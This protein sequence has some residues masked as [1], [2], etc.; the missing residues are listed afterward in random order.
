MREFEWSDKQGSRDRKA[1][2]LLVK[3][4]KI[5]AFEGANV[6][7]VAAIKGSDYEKSGKWS[8]TT[9]RLILA[10]G[11]QAHPLRAGWETGTFR[12]AIG[13]DTWIEAANWL[14]VS[15]P[16]VQG[17]LREWAPKTACHYDEVD[18]SL[19]ELDEA[20]CETGGID[21]ITISFGS[22]TSRER[23]NGYWDLP[24]IVLDDRQQVIDTL[25]PSGDYMPSNERVKLLD[26]I[27]TSGHGGG[28][29]SLRLAVPAGSTAKH[30]Y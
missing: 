2:L 17:F 28:Y 29:I 7:G 5:Y 11:V 25:S 13:A 15:I 14:N 1:W 27:R 26:K 4:D 21:V 8:H 6:P 3:A 12:E 23:E 9:Y 10:N 16:S 22:P 19:I 18:A 24:V 30:G 20:E